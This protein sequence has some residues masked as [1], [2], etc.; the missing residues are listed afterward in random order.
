M[1]SRRRFNLVCLAMLTTP[2]STT[3]SSAEALP[4]TVGGYVF[5]PFVSITADGSPKGLTIE[6]IDWLN[7]AQADYRFSFFLTSPARRFADFE[8]GHFDMMCFESPDWG[9]KS[10]SLSIDATE[11]FLL[12][13]DLF[14]ARKEDGRTQSFFQDLRGKRI[15]GMWG[16]HYAFTGFERDP[17]KLESEHGMI[18]VNDNR[19]AIELVLA[20]RADLAI[21]ARSYLEY[22]FAQ[23]GQ[24]DSG[25]L[26]SD[27]PDQIYRYRA[28]VRADSPVEASQLSKW[29]SR[30][31]DEL[32]Y[33]DRWMEA[34]GSL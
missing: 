10:R 26:M 15:A 32:G 1:I 8:A 18:L 5:P 20:G 28:L 24:E 6:M 17:R 27:T 21:V 23:M 4:I 30:A 25:L 34:S 2:L 33:K 19:A 22:Y 12:D 9:W 31:I 7:A 3:L 16:Y 13:Y 14:V 29:T 11:V